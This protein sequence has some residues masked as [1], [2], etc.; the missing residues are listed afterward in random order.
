MAKIAIKTLKVQSAEELGC[1]IAAVG[2]AQNFAAIR[3]L[4]TEGIHR[5]HM[6]LHIRN[7]ILQCGAALDVVDKIAQM[8]VS[9]NNFTTQRAKELIEH[10]KICNVQ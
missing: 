10:L 3:A 6:K 9:E 2:L 5:G 1:V 4:V 8:M 7:I